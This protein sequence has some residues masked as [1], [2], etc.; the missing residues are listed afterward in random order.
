MNRNDLKNPLIQSGALLLFAFLLIS[1]VAGSGSEGIGGSI[2][3]LISGLVS[4]VVFI[5]A[6]CFAIIISIAIII[7]IYVAA[8]SI[9]S[10]DKGRDLV[11]QLKG[12]LSSFSSKLGDFK[13]PKTEAPVV[14]PE[15][16][17]PRS[18]TPDILETPVAAPSTMPEKAPASP[19]AATPGTG[20]VEAKIGGFD[21]QLNKISE[22]TTSC[23]KQLDALQRQVDDLSDPAAA[24]ARV[25]AVEETQQA[26]REQ[27]D[28]ISA[29]L[30]SHNTE[31]EKLSQRFSDELETLK[32]EVASLHEK[33]S[34]PEVISGILSYI[35]SQEDRDL[36]TGKAEEA[37]SRNMTYSQID[38]FF[39]DS[40]P[41]GVY[42][43]LAA[44][45]RLTKDF[46]RSI[47]KKF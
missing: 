39:K 47:K 17:S 1:I 45:P 6:L 44:H 26:L 28:K 24:E 20:V 14:A 33:T 15:T 41:S 21:K 3:A 27:L 8:V 34:V 7:G 5:V 38:D 2:G 25:T 32:Q 13:K 10:V 43:E 16:L 22:A 29:G 19:A 37:I 4:A 23:R 31:I 12:S 30:E 36:V 11:D 18:E 35:D 40:L 46:L 9:Y 42:Q